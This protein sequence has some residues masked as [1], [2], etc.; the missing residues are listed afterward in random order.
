M[1]DV[2]ISLIVSF[3]VSM[4]VLKRSHGWQAFIIAVAIGA[5]VGWQALNVFPADKTSLGY[6]L[7]T[8]PE[9]KIIWE[10]THDI[11]TVVAYAEHA[12]L[13][14]VGFNVIGAAIGYFLARKLS[15]WRT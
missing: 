5:L 9:L 8:N 4:V 10:Q 13:I 1:F 14:L 11:R 2:I 15:R 3:I 6:L 7:S 12:Y